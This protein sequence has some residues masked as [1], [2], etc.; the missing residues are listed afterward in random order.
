[1]PWWDGELR[2]NSESSVKLRME[3]L[4]GWW[5]TKRKDLKQRKVVCK[6]EKIQIEAGNEK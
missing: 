4:N 6:A 2:G 3:V 5:M 1:M